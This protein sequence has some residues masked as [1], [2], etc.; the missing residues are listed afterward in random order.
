MSQNGSE[1]GVRLVCEQSLLNFDYPQL[2]LLLFY[3][4]IYVKRKLLSV[5][6]KT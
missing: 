4:H 6:Y 5:T 2:T 3:L 1:N